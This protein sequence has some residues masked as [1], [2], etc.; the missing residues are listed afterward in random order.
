[1]EHV[2]EWKCCLLGIISYVLKHQ[3]MLRCITG[4]RFQFTLFA[5][6]KKR[7]IGKSVGRDRKTE[8]PAGLIQLKFLT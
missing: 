1:M 5:C 2:N 6:R 4:I 3:T 7:Q 8:V